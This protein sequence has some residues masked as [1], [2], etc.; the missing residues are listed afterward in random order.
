VSVAA[1]APNV[2]SLRLARSPLVVTALATV[3]YALLIASALARGHGAAEFALVGRDAHGQTAAIA[4]YAPPGPT[5]GYDG[6]FAL[7]I[8]LDP[9]HARSALDAPVYRYSHI[10]YPMTARALA[11]GSAE[12]VPAAMLLMNLLALFAGTC[13]VALLLQRRGASPWLALIFSFFPGMV[14]SVASDLNE[15]LA[16]ACVAWALWFLDWRSRRR[17]AAAALL[18]AA[19]ALARETT[20]LFPLV[21]AAAEAWRARRLLAPALVAAAAVVPYASW[22]L[23]LL[24]WLGT[25][26]SHPLQVLGFPFGG[27][28]AQHGWVEVVEWLTVMLP[29][30]L[31]LGGLAVSLIRTRTLTTLEL[32]LLASLLV[33]TMLGPASFA[34]YTSASRLQIGVVLAALIVAPRT[35]TAIRLRLVAA[36]LAFVPLLAL[37]SSVIAGGNRPL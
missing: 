14:L 12:R 1:T 15:P 21:L 18:F 8:A 16:F 20:L 24:L 25:T 37:L 36:T 27:L 5:K 32:P 4:Q 26:G 10:L 23:V 34:D 33:A 22:R 9:L 35:V 6:Q 11:L 29:V 30:L 7:F 19:A 2:G 17:L 13:A 31:L 28:L 3:V